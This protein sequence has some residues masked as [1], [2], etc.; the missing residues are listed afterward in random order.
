MLQLE[1]D[2]PDY[3]SS[4]G[5]PMAE[6]DLHRDMMLDLIEAL[7]RHFSG[8]R[9]VY[10][11]GNLL[12]YYE[13]GNPKACLAPDVLVALDRPSHRREIYKLWEEGKAPDLVIEVTS[14]TTRRSDTGKKRAIYES[15]GVREYVLFDPRR[16]YLKPRFQV[17][18]LE[19]SGF[20]PV[21]IPENGCYT[22]PLLGLSF[23]VRDDE[24]RV[25]VTPE[26]PLLPTIAEFSST[27]LRAEAVAQQARAEAE[28][29]KAEAEKAKAEVDQAKAEAEKARRYADR[30]RELGIDPESLD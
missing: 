11:S 22:S 30:L 14:R 6:S 24:L 18:R 8:P 12:L 13:R 20:V 19:N 5:K 28:Q 9:S 3:P 7:R 26:G 17:F 23:L 16:D 2:E 29:A 10:V 15:L 4:D 25:A 21:L 1:S 27:A